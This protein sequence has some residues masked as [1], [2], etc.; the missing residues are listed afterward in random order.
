MSAAATTKKAKD[1]PIAPVI[2]WAVIIHNPRSS[3]IHWNTIHAQRSGAWKRYLDTWRPEHQ[4]R[5][6]ADRKQGR[7]TLAKVSVLA[8]NSPPNFTKARQG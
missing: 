6:E 4:E 5:A 3:W 7:L 1:R 8:L 2:L